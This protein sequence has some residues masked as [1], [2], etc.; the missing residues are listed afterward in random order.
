MSY[1]VHLEADLGAGF[2]R[3]GYLDSNMTWNIAPIVQRACGTSPSQWDGMT[4]GDVAKIAATVAGEIERDPATYEALNP[5][6]G[7]GS[8]DG[9]LKWMREICDACRTAP[10]AIFRVC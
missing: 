2:I 9:C 3:V 7:W 10:N 8:A 6:N 5:A 1:D 4:A